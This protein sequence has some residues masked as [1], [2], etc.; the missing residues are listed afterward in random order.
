M[1]KYGFHGNNLDINRLNTKRVTVQDKI[2]VE[3]VIPLT[4]AYGTGNILT[5]VDWSAAT[6]T[7]TK[8]NFKMQPPYPAQLSVTAMSAGTAGHNDKITFVGVN[9]WGSTVYDSVYV[10]GTAAGVSYTNNAYAKITSIY[11]TGKV[12]IKSTSVS[13]GVRSGVIGLP[14][15]I[16]TSADFISYQKGGTY[17]TTTPITLTSTT[18]RTVTIATT[19]AK[20]VKIIYKSKLQKD[21]GRQQ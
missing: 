15:P 11:P 14:Y 3:Y 19:A 17:A 8:T 10:S 18:Y 21:W 9:A 2:P 5:D 4:I 7:Q 12:V 20:V 1:S 6:T 16:A 13:I